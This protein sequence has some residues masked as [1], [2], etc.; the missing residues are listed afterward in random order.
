MSNLFYKN[1]KI[2]NNNQ[3]GYNM[4]IGYNI[5]LNKNFISKPRIDQIRKNLHF[6][7]AEQNLF[8]KINIKSDLNEND[9][10]ICQNKGNGNCYYKA[11]SQFYY[12]TENYHIYYRKIILE[13]IESKKKQKL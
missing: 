5:L 9:I 1:T 12:N 2:S 10:N 8:R 13:Y 11:L 3:M 4:E 7:N 6:I